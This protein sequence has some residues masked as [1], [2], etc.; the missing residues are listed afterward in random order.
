LNEGTGNLSRKSGMSNVSQL[1]K[2]SLFKKGKNKGMLS[3]GI[4]GKEKNR[5]RNNKREEKERIWKKPRMHGQ[6]QR[7]GMGFK[8]RVGPRH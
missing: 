3:H 6:S 2:K 4:R 5:R 1:G 8:K 7:F